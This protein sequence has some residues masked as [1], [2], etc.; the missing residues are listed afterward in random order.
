MDHTSAKFN[1][2]T[3][4]RLCLAGVVLSS[5]L[6][7]STAGHATPSESYMRTN[8]K[9]KTNQLLRRNLQVEKHV[10]GKGLI[11]F[12]DEPTSANPTMPGGPRSCQISSESSAYVHPND[13]STPTMA[14][15]VPFVYEVET[16]TELTPG[17]MNVFVLPKVEQ[18][19]G[20][21]LLPV[22]FDE[23]AVG[24]GG[25]DDAMTRYLALD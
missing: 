19:L 17:Q 23:C 12:F 22:L 4:R 7:S 24:D 2:R 5:S 6:S 8:A 18:V 13:S 20:N 10:L 16:N 1:N 25:G 15:E 11:T 21:E 9:A 14:M 3:R